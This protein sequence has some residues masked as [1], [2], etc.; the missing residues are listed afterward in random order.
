MRRF[1]ICTLHQT[2]SN[3]KIVEDVRGGAEVRLA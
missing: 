3:D 1:I 2:Y